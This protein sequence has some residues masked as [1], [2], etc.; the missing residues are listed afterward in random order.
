VTSFKIRT[1][2]LKIANV[3]I[4]PNAPLKDVFDFV[5]SILKNAHPKEHILLAGDFNIDMSRNGNDRQK[6]MS[7]MNNNNFTLHMEAT[8]CNTGSV[9]DHF[10][11]NLDNQDIQFAISEAYWTDHD[12]ISLSI[13]LQ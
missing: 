5:A 9:L 1:L 4:A 7:F 12:A 13:P 8:T 11:S 6:F 2:S 10:W 3:Y